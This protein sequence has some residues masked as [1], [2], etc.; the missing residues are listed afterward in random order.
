MGGLWGDFISTK[1][2]QM[3]I[4]VRNKIWKR[5]MSCFGVDFQSI[6][7]HIGYNSWH[8]EPIEYDNGEPKFFHDF[9]QMILK[10]P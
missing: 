3:P 6:L 9:D 5:I 7:L 1:Y 8:F 4:Y 2:L 10:W